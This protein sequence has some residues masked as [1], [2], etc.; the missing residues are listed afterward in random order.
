MKILTT[1]I[2]DK[3]VKCRTF[4]KVYVTLVSLFSALSPATEGIN[5][6][7]KEVNKEDGKKSNG[8]T[9]PLI[10]PYKLI[11]LAEDVPYKISL[12]GINMFSIIRSAEFIQ[13]V[14]VKGIATSKILEIILSAPAV[15]LFV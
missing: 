4:D 13:E 10:I 9:I 14:A 11:A 8:K 12:D 6:E 3:A 7:A 2:P 5:I 1:I 15:I